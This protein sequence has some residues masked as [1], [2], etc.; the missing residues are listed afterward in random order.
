MVFRQRELSIKLVLM[1][2]K[3]NKYIILDR[4]GT[5]IEEKNYLHE[6]NQVSLLPGVIDGLKKLALEGY[7]FI[8][9][10][11]QS[12]IGR[13]YFSES[14]MFSVN[15]RLSSILLAEGI[16]IS[17]FY[18]C[19]HKPEDGCRCRK[20]KPGMVHDACSELGLTIEDIDCVI[21]DKKSDV[22]LADNIGA[23]SVLVLTGYG[24]TV[25]QKDARACFV[26]EDI[27]QAADF[28]I[29]NLEM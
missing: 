21:G 5:L 2:I 17:G 14:D 8:V 7:K 10:T 13:G 4:D 12:G 11:N 1:K 20:P 16:E 15:Q 29:K 24:R 27:D 6:P 19:P 23:V 3:R 28:I 22:E 18:Y 26:A 25:Y 9:L